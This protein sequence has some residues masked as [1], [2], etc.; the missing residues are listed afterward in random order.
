MKIMLDAF[1]E[2]CRLGVKKGEIVLPKDKELA[3]LHLTD[4][5]V[6]TLFVKAFE[7]QDGTASDGCGS[8]YTAESLYY[9]DQNRY[10]RQ[11]FW[12]HRNGCLT[13]DQI[14]FPPKNQ[15]WEDFVN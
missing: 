1:S 9:E 10:A 7:S 12:A 11:W 5:E 15:S 13:D 8:R 14:D 4:T 2:C 3:M 6:S